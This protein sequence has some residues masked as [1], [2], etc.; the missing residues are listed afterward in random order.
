MPLNTAVVGGESQSFVHE[1]DARWLMAYAA[2]LGD[3]STAYLDTKMHP[4]T[5]HPVFP[6]CLEWPALLD[7]ANIAGAD[8]ATA[9]ERARGV[10]TARTCGLGIAL[11]ARIGVVAGWKRRGESPSRARTLP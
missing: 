8:T 1:V 3:T 10:L 6:V 7:C 4:V 9:E 11:A 5:A 2:G